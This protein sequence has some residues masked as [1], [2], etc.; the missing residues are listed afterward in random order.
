MLFTDILEFSYFADFLACIFKTRVESG[1]LFKSASR[2]TANSMEQKLRVFRQID[3]QEFHHS[4]MQSEHL[5]GCSL[6]SYVQYYKPYEA[7][8][9]CR[10]FKCMYEYKSLC[11]TYYILK[12]HRYVEER[13]ADV[14]A[15]V[16]E[17]L[18]DSQ[19]L[20]FSFILKISRNL[21]CYFLPPISIF[22]CQWGFPHLAEQRPTREQ[23]R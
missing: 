7:I 23:Q 5:S 13:D 21:S 2:N 22:F 8:L 4:R 19:F 12:S 18:R 17:R 16:L 9:L 3:E 1:L 15:D 10:H 11:N 20:S 6:Y 14:N